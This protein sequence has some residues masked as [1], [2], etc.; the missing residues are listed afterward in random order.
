LKELQEFEK[1]KKLRGH[2]RLSDLNVIRRF[3]DLKAWQCGRELTNAVYSLTQNHQFRS[4]YALVDQIRRAAVS[5]MN[6][7][8]EGFERGSN[9]DFVKFLF[10]A[11]GSA[12]EVR[13]LLYIARDQ[14]YITKEEFAA[15][16]D[17][18]IQT[19]RIIWG[20]IKSLRDKKDWVIGQK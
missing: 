20:L 9:K 2:S 11:R 5:V 13:S 17:L 3:E 1:L 14:N 12:G 15:N 10:I 18:S 16:Y 19:S 4:D 8:A 7:V 6:N